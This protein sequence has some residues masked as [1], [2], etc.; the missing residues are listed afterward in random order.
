MSRDSKGER[1]R[2][3]DIEVEIEGEREREREI[4]R[5]E[6]IEKARARGKWRE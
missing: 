6:C 2:G 4:Q 3:I 5:E 1:D